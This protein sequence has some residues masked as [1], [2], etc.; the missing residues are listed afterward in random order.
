MSNRV[1]VPVVDGLFDVQD[2]AP[3]L[4]GAK[5]PE[6]GTHYFPRRARCSNPA[7]D[8]HEAQSVRLSA[9]GTLYSYSVQAYR[10]PPLFG[11]EP[12]APYAIGLVDLPEGVRVMTML[13]G[14]APD[15]FRIGSPMELRLEPL[16]LDAD[17]RDVLTWKFAPA[18]PAP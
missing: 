4:V 9:R 14:A 7:C 11:M 5:C 1:S 3:A 15:E 6:C 10:P 8:G 18:E 17:G 12:W 2:G 13:T 16:R